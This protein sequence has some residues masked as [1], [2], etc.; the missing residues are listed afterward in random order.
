M[1]QERKPALAS[2][3]TLH[4][5]RKV[6]K[7]VHQFK[8]LGLTLETQGGF[9]EAIAQLCA[10][11]RRAAFA[12][13][14]QCCRRGISSLDCILKLFNAK[15]LP[16]LSY[17]CEVWFGTFCN[18]S[19]KR[20]WAEAAELV[21]RDFLRGILGVSR[22]APTAAEYAEFGTYPLA[23]H[24][25]RLAA[26]FQNRAQCM[27]DDRPVRWAATYWGVPRSGT[28]VTNTVDVAAA[29]EVRC[30]KGSYTL[31]GL[32]LVPQY[33]RDVRLQEGLEPYLCHVKIASHRRALACL[34]LSCNE[35]RV[36]TARTVKPVR[37][38]REERVCRLCSTGAVEDEL[39]ILTTCPALAALRAGCP[40]L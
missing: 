15:V 11:A 6:L 21:Y 17:G 4:Y 25:A 37:P 5:N 2:L 28:D 1:F 3:P 35:L 24:W 23:V 30:F 16:I 36:C 20:R 38:P 31:P 13:R 7:K 26:R 19:T 9:R 40:D 12:V 22:R 34:R 39:H 10:S 14:H 27:E 33:F 18:D 29:E 32:T 8:Y